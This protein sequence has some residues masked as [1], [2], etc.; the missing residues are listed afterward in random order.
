MPNP[1]RLYL[2]S[3]RGHLEWQSPPAVGM[4][5]LVGGFHIIRKGWTLLNRYAMTARRFNEGLLA[6]CAPQGIIDLGLLRVPVVDA[7]RILKDLGPLCDGKGDRFR[8]KFDSH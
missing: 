2:N 4:D 1:S 3:G 7:T 8:S 6:E 5:C